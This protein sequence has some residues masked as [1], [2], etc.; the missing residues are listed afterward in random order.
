MYEFPPSNRDGRRLR[1]SEPAPMAVLSPLMQATCGAELTDFVIIQAMDTAAD[2]GFAWEAGRVDRLTGS[3][4][5]AAY[6]S[7]AA[8][9]SAL[10]VPERNA[11]HS[12]FSNE[13]AAIALR[14]WQAVTRVRLTEH[15]NAAA[16]LQCDLTMVAVAEAEGVSPESVMYLEA[17]LVGRTLLQ[18][19][20]Y[21]EPINPR[22]YTLDVL[23]FAYADAIISEAE[24]QR[25]ARSARK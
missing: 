23:M 21:G 7:S 4:L 8:T 15:S 1:L 17:E 14:F 19:A 13:D 12:I 22:D 24:R 16:D 3:A 9:H 2:I 5:R 6:L 25:D 11:D 10:I 18:M 20:D